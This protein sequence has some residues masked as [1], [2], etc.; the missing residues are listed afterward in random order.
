MSCIFRVRLFL[1]LWKCF[2]PVISFWIYALILLMPES[3][4][5]DVLLSSLRSVVS[6][7]IILPTP[8]RPNQRWPVSYTPSSLPKSWKKDQFFLKSDSFIWTI[9][10]HT[11]ALLIGCCDQSV[12]YAVLSILVICED[13][14]IFLTSKLFVI[15]NLPSSSFP[16]QWAA[17]AGQGCLVLWVFFFLFIPTN[18]PLHKFHFFQIK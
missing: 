7:N 6:V 16:V 18:P 10:N 15:I 4:V 9:I 12:K 3:V 1:F 2:H 13:I 17:L 11:S 14:N 8:S 5:S